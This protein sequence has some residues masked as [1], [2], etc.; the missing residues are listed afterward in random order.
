MQ[1]FKS[2]EK[3]EVL[4]GGNWVVGEYA[5]AAGGTDHSVLTDGALQSIL[6]FDRNIRPLQSRKRVAVRILDAIGT[7]EDLRKAAVQGAKEC[8][9]KRFA[10]I[11][12][13]EEIVRVNRDPIWEKP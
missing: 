8:E 1:Q 7:E 6:F 3:V 9:G 5:G 13:P 12:M 2:G 4:I 10:V 11:D